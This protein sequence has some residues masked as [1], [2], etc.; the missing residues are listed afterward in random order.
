VAVDMGGPSVR[1]LPMCRAGPQRACTNDRRE[2]DV[3]FGE[4]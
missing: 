1:L 2:L 4:R 3:M